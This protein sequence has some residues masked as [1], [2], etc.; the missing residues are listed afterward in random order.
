MSNVRRSQRQDDEVGTEVVSHPPGAVGLDL[1]LDATRGTMR[2]L[3][4]AVFTELN[5]VT[6]R[7]GYVGETLRDGSDWPGTISGADLD[8]AGSWLYG[9]GHAFSSPDVVQNSHGPI[10]GRCAGGFQ[11]EDSWVAWTGDR[12]LVTRPGEH[13]LGASEYWNNNKNVGIP[14][15][16][17]ILRPVQA[18]E[19][20]D[21]QFSGSTL[22]SSLRV[23]AALARTEFSA[24]VIDRATGVLL[25]KTVFDDTDHP[26]IPDFELVSV[27]TSGETPFI[28]A[29]YQETDLY[30]WRW[31]GSAWD[32]TV[33]SGVDGYAV[34]ESPGGL[35]VAMRRSGSFDFLEYSGS[36]RTAANYMPYTSP[37]PSVAPTGAVAM[38]LDPAG[39]L[40]VAYLA[41]GSRDTVRLLVLESNLSIRYDRQV[42]SG[43]TYDSLTVTTR[44]LLGENTVH[45]TIVYTETS[46]L[47]RCD[48]YNAQTQLTEANWGRNNCELA[49]HAFRVGEM[50]AVWLL[51]TV[52]G[53]AF[54][55]SGSHHPQTIAVV[56]REDASTQYQPHF[57][58]GLSRMVA[59]P[60]APYQYTITTHLA[61]IKTDGLR[62]YTVD[63]MPVM[64]AVR[65]GNSVYLSGSVVRNWDG[66]HL[67]DAGFHD[68]PRT[69]SVTD[70]GVGVLSAGDYRYR[71]YSVWTNARGEKFRSPA[72]TSV[73]C[74]VAASR[75]ITITI[76]TT[77][78]GNVNPFF[79][80]Y[81]TEAN[82]EAFF[83]EGLVRNSQSSASVTFESGTV[84]T[85]AVL[86]TRPLDPH[87]P[88]LDADGNAILPE[89]EEFGPVGCE[90]LAVVG[91]RL[92]GAGGQ[93][94]AGSVQFSKLKELTEGTGFGD[95]ISQQV[96]DLQGNAITS[97]VPM[98]SGVC[99]FQADTLFVVSGDGP[100]NTGVGVFGVTELRLAGGAS[101]HVGSAQTQ[102]GTLYWGPNGPRLLD[103]SLRVQEISL[104][105]RS[106]VSDVVPVGVHSD[107]KNQRVTWFHAGGAVH[108]N[109]EREPRW[110]LW[111][112]PDVVAVM[113]DGSLITPTGRVLMPVDGADDD[114]VPFALTVETGEIVGNDS[115]NEHTILQGVGWM[116]KYLDQ[117]ELRVRV[118]I[119][120]EESWGEEWFWLPADNS[121]L[122]SEQSFAAL[123]PAQIDALGPVDR[124]G[125]YYSFKR[126]KTNNVRS[127]RVS[128]SDVSSHSRT[129]V[130]HEISYAV[131]ARPGFARTT[132][133]NFG[134]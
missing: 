22:S 35:H 15:Q 20:F 47:V 27:V 129:L 13:A 51:A 52:N 5:S 109:L 19:P 54:A 119:N 86:A 66:Y 11:F 38:A 3:D 43:S 12:L 29:L 34:T 79:E 90:I 131:G 82:G 17:P 8:T 59:D 80:V 57:E 4:N 121:W 58:R 134:D 45:N 28:F 40:H 78:M 117:H 48:E 31:L 60:T 73:V 1:R 106:A 127:F 123:T 7:G 74:T 50:N 105:I 63:F 24:W 95:G 97:I 33:E 26:S 98:A 94:P 9:H 49:S 6:R 72:V 14:A 93:L 42:I 100:S 70:T 91:D 96:V 75:K 128:L 108:L 112:T 53:T 99:V 76:S 130:L 77:P 126:T 2:R 89:T 110:S 23:I 41:G 36:N 39:L 115:L 120:R 118:S 125:T 132:V 88:G 16:L 44:Q 21:P 114:G 101:T 85:D 92:W 55:L 83:L 84:F 30:I 122:S 104:P 62:V 71:V 64:D 113:G 68:Y 10:P 133:T 56:N 61:R 111:T 65:Y 102:I 107:N 67:G 103:Q 87:A 69:L 124:S 18:P 116:G 81:R 25:D 32:V 46:G 37:T